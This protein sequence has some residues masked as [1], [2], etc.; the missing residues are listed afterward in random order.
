MRGRTKKI[1]KELPNL[2]P[3]GFP[4]K[5]GNLFGEDVDLDLL[6]LFPQMGARIMEGLRER[7]LTREV[8]NGEKQWREKSCWKRG[9]RKALKRQ[10]RKTSRWGRKWLL[11][12]AWAG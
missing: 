6:S 2:D 3:N 10:P 4:H 1:H 11:E 9:G 5:E 7:Q 8:T 12:R